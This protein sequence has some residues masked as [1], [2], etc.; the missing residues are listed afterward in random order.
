M[1]FMQVASNQFL[2][3]FVKW[4]SIIKE[5]AKSMDV[6]PDQVVNDPETSS[7][8]YEMMGDMNGNQQTQGNNQQQGGMGLLEEYLQE[9]MSQTHKGLEVATSESELHR[10]QG[11]VAIL[12]QIINLRT[13]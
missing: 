6:D 10:L 11:K 4:H 9:Q 2:A 7:N 8:L 12:H 1:T 5:I 3:P 13:N